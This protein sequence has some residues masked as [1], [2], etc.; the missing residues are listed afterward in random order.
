MR[1]LQISDH[2]LAQSTLLIAPAHRWDEMWLELVQA[3]HIADRWHAGI[4]DSP[5]TVAHVRDLQSVMS[6]TPIVDIKVAAIPHA[7]RMSKEV[8]NA[9][10]KLLE[11]PP[12]FANTVL[13]AESAEVLPTILS[14]VQVIR[15]PG[16]SSTQSG[17]RREQIASVLSEY[18]ITSSVQRKLAKELLSTI[19]LPIIEEGF[20]PPTV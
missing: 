15:L 9:L 4:W 1:L 17:T 5:L 6:R 10:L 20:R 19:Q 16:E 14:R 12:P 13:F 7:D 11:E 3:V 8:A 18:A 2:I